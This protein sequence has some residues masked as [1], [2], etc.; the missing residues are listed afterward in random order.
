MC[1]RARAERRERERRARAEPPAATDPDD[2][3]A[4]AECWRRIERALAALRDHTR[5]TFIAVDLEADP[6]EEVAKRRGVSRRMIEKD[7]AAA[8]RAVRAAIDDLRR[9]AR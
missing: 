5:E 2:E 4:E 3:L 1:D 7:L 9:A 6:I 8:R